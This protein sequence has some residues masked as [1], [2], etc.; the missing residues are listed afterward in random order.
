MEKNTDFTHGVNY[1]SP[2]PDTD[3][4]IL[5][6]WG[7]HQRTTGK[8]YRWDGM[9][10]G[11]RKMVLWQYTIDGCGML[12]INDQNIPVRRGEAFLLQVPEKHCYFLPDD[13]GA[14]E[15]LYFGFSGEEAWRLTE[16]L[17]FRH[18]S[19][20]SA[21][22]APE[23]I[24]TAWELLRC[25]ENPLTPPGTASAL[26]YKLLM[27]MFSP[28]SSAAAPDQLLLEKI[29]RYIVA[30]IAAGVSLDDLA[31]FAGYSRSHFC[32]IFRESCGKSAHEYLL[33]V[34][35][36]IALLKLQSENISVKETAE[37]CGFSDCSYFCK[38]F[39]KF[40]GSTPAHFLKRRKI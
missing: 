40:H 20:S 33:K 27:T 24:E 39:R 2:V 13:P 26:A 10:R 11:S 5:P 15:F 22:A 30:H 18:G 1:L 34:K 35:M 9:R 37:A 14:W 28:A 3:L 31:A 38:V 29:H 32:K 8:R 4:A 16:K 23:G 7:G 6:V 19:V 12:N 21:F 25:M 17:R 36:E